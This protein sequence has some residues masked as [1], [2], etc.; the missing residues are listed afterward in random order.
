MR[1]VCCNMPAANQTNQPT[2]QKVTSQ[3]KKKSKEEGWRMNAKSCLGSWLVKVR[4][5]ER[6]RK[7]E[8][9]RLES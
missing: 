3:P 2:K 4:E 6:A 1:L 5:S 9:A 8:S 7:G